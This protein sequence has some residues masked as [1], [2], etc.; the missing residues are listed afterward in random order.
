MN[1]QPQRAVTIANDQTMVAMIKSATHR[2]ILMAPAVTD[3]VA[4]ALAERWQTL[5][6]NAVTVI[7]DVSPE[8]FRLGFGDFT[9]LQLL[10]TTARELGVTL[11]R[12]PGIRIGLLIV[13]EQ[14]LIYSPT[15]R[16][17]EAGPKQPDTPN[18]I[19][20]GIPPADVERELGAGPQGIKGR[21][22][23]LDKAETA[24]I[25][26]VEKELKD[27]PPQE[28]NVARLVN[29]FNAYFEFVELTLAGIFIERRTVSIPTDLLLALETAT[30]RKIHTTYKLIEADD[31][32]SS[33]ALMDDR[34]RLVKKHLRVIPGFGMAILRTGKQKFMEEFAIL[35]NGV[36][37]FK[38]K[39]SKSLK[40]KLKERREALQAQLL[41]VVSKQVPQRWTESAF[42]KEG[43]EEDIKALLEQELIE[44]F[45]TAEQLVRDMLAGVVFKA[46]TYESLRNQEFMKRAKEAFPELQT[47]Y[48][49]D[50]AV[51]G[52]T[53]VA[54]GAT[55]AAA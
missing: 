41:P 27:C 35:E 52:R 28:F 50:Q 12:Q 46:V 8:V 49:E 4:V 37:A 40:E 2:V 32:L 15:P 22:L 7:V 14:T 24:A 47:L 53:P 30:Q 43:T 39:V 11:D 10:E 29:V 23:G 51:K 44:V 20:L 34:N 45:G 9:A 48:E 25:T 54:R 19:R 38:E 33:K 16:L 31:A 13:D 55:P 26:K 6:G 3:E 5:G 42:Y 21:L 17:I 36:K 1:G 18:A